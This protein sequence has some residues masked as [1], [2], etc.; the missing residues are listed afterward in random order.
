MLKVM[1][2][3]SSSSVCLL[4]STVF[5]NFPL[6]E[7]PP[8]K[9]IWISFFKPLLV[10]SRQDAMSWRDVGNLVNSFVVNWFSFTHPI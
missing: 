2:L 5:G 1:S 10:I 8:G 3:M 4:E 9:I 6:D 7:F